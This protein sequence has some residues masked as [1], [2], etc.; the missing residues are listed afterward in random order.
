MSLKRLDVKSIA[1]Y[2][3]KKKKINVEEIDNRMTS[4]NST[5]AGL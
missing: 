3:G 2:T 1:E 5:K 4:V